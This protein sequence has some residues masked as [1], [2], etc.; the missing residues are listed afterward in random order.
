MRKKYSDNQHDCQNDPVEVLTN[1]LSLAQND[2]S[3]ESILY[4]LN[5]CC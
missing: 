5:V 2:V 1:I 3:S 4:D